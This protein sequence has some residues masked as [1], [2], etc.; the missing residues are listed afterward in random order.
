MF[1]YKKG[2][3]GRSKV[4]ESQHL[5]ERLLSNIILVAVP[6]SAR[7]SMPHFSTPHLGL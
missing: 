6:P 4:E 2:N 1:V 3:A 5:D 7:P